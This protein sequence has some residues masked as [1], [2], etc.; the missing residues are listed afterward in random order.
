VRNEPSNQR[1]GALMGEF[2][3]A[4]Y[5]LIRAGAIVVLFLVVHLA[6]LREY[7]TFLSGTLAN[8]EVSFRLSAF[9]GMTYIVLYLGAVVVGPI[10]VLAAGLLVLRKRLVKTSDK[11]LSNSPLP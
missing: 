9:Y 5:F 1:S 4:K 6:G 3:T 11:S 8:P 2:F 10:L 7:T